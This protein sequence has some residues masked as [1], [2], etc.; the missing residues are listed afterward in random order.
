MEGFLRFAQ[1][2][3]GVCPR[4]GYCLECQQDAA[5]RVDLQ[6]A[7][8]RG[9]ELTCKGHVRTGLRAGRALAGLVT[10]EHRQPGHAHCEHERAGQVHR[11]AP[12]PV[13]GPLLFFSTTRLGF[14]ALAFGLGRATRTFQLTLL[15]LL[16]CGR[17]AFGLGQACLHEAAFERDQF[18]VVCVGPLARLFQSGPAVQR[19]WVTTQP[20]PPLGAFGNVLV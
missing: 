3:G 2:G 16:A 19:I 9:R 7:N 8:R 18:A 4:I 10:E 20:L 11:A 6:V 5:F 15:L 1:S 13:A 14:G 12:Q 17:L